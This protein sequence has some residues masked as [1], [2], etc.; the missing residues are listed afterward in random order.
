[1]FKAR[2]F[3]GWHFF[4]DDGGVF[5]PVIQWRKG[6]GRAAVN[7]LCGCGGGRMKRFSSREWRLRRIFV[8]VDAAELAAKL[9]QRIR[10]KPIQCPR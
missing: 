7:G 9:A 4:K 10:T 2:C 3:S 6:G 1:M 5:D 8:R